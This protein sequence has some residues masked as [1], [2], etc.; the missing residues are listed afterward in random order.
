MFA[1]SLNHRLQLVCL[2]YR[3]QKPLQ[4]TECLSLRKEYLPTLFPCLGFSPK[5]F[6][7]Q[8]GVLS[9]HSYCHSFDRTSMVHSSSETVLRKSAT[10]STA[11]KYGVSV[12]RKD[13]ASSSRKQ[14]SLRIVTL[15]KASVIKAFLEELPDIF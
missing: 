14:K 8:S 7:D 6:K 12:Q 13:S 5:F 11:T 2:Q 1:T 15:L 4:S 3:I 9:D 10:Y